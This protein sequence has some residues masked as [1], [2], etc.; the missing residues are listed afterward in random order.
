MALGKALKEVLVNTITSEQ[1]SDMATL[2]EVEDDTPVDIK[3]F[4]GIAALAERILYPDF[5]YVSTMC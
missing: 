4:S 3:L 5:V 2:L 1:V